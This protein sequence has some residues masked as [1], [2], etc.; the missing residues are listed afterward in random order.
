MRKGIINSII[1]RMKERAKVGKESEDKAERILSIYTRLKMGKV[2]FK[3]KESA[4]FGVAT[5]TIQRDIADIQCFLQN[6]TMESGE[7]QEIIFDKKIG[8]Y[9]LQTKSRMQFE[10]KEILAIAKVLLESRSLMKTEL[11]PMIRKLIGICNDETEEK[12]LEDLLKNEMFHYVELQHGK[13]LL[14]RIWELEQAVKK[15]EYIEIQY[16]RLKN[17]ELVTR[18]VKP[19]GIM[20]SEFY[21]YLTAYIEDIDKEARFQNPNDTYPTIYRI[22]RLLDVKRLDEYFKIPYADRFEEGEFKKRVQFMY[23]GRLRK[24]IFLYKGN[25]IDFILDRLP[26][27]EILQKNKDGVVVQAEVFGDGI[28]MWLRS[29]GN[30]IELTK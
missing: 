14:D 10:G 3:E 22:D 21:F 26:T 16:K 9:I 12:L 4:E 28:D 15:Q 30:D 11:F 27:A 5:R 29:Q 18:K 25:S 24:I 19:V 17:H 6:Q 13:H 2:I 1:R 23:G 20:F 8:G 7:V